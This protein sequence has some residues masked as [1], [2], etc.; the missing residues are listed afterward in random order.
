M[1]NME[2]LYLGTLLG[3][4]LGFILTSGKNI[5]TSIYYKIT[6]LISY[7]VYF[8]ANND[9]YDVFSEWFQE[10]Y[11]DKFR[12]NEVKITETS[13]APK[14]RLKFFQL[15]DS[16]CIWYKNRLIFI[17]KERLKLEHTAD[18]SNLFMHSYMLRGF[19]AKE[20]INELCEELLNKHLKK[21]QASALTVKCNSEW[22]EYIT[23]RYSLIKNFDNLF[24]K[25]KQSLLDDINSFLKSKETYEKLGITYK[26]GYLFHG[27]PGTGKSSIA[28]A[29]A[30]HANRTLY[31]I[32]LASIQGGDIYLQKLICN[33]PNGSC[34]VFEDIDCVVDNR[35]TD[36]K[37]EFNFSTL[38][39]LLDGLYS[40]EDVIF[41][42]TTNH[43]EKLDNA[44]L[45]K[46]RMDFSL[47]MNHPRNQDVEDFINHFFG[48]N[49]KLCNPQDISKCS[50]ADI[51]NLCLSNTLEQVLEHVN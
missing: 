5:I 19:F 38:L 16:N 23:R 45:R 26:R 10:K 32:N 14:F 44:L 39:N 8:D 29:I 35:K 20:A 22:G 13:K 4:L 15:A 7:S 27:P 41:I 47:E 1:R 31:S 43:I 34:V 9:M 36:E 51:Q 50:M 30:S 21:T 40:P 49:I 12:R 28:K 17:S 3:G 46:G 25:D 37:S 6:S 33:V 2:Q 18:L 48:S 11:P 42:I 24:F